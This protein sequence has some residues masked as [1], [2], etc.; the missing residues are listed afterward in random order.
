MINHLH[1]RVVD[2]L[3]AAATATLATQGPAGLQ[4]NTFPCEAVELVLY[5]LVPRTS[6]QLFNLEQ[7]PE[8]VVTAEGWQ[9]RGTARIAADHP[10]GLALLGQPEAPYCEVVEIH[11]ARL[12]IE[13]EG[14]G[15]A[16]TID[17]DA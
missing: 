2:T 14:T 3:S 16:E 5:V 17:V 4:A 11:P 8:V 7:N 9:L 1:Q 10:A 15:H 12:Q 6:D 13:R